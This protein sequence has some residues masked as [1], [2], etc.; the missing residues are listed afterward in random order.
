MTE[1]AAVDKTIAF[2]IDIVPPGRRID[3]IARKLARKV[4]NPR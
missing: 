3:L 1:A 4:T 2:D